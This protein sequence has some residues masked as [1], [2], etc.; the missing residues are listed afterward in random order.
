MLSWIQLHAIREQ[1]IML[2]SCNRNITLMASMSFTMQG[3]ALDL[4]CIIS[5]LCV[6]ALLQFIMH[7]VFVILIAGC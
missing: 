2:L 6:A 1:H 7:V 4:V 5:E 3:G